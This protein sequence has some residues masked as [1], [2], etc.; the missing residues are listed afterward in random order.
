MSPYEYKMKR[1]PDRDALFI[2]V[3]G[4]PVQ[5]EPYGEDLHKKAPKTEWGYYVGVQWLMVLVL[6]E[7]DWKVISVSRKKELCHE[8]RYAKSNLPMT[9]NSIAD[10]TKLKADLESLKSESEGLEVIANYKETFNIPELNEA[11]PTNPPRQITEAFSPHPAV[12]GKYLADH[13]SLELLMEELN[14]VKEKIRRIDGKEG[15]AEAML[16]ALKKLE[17]EVQNTAVRKRCLKKGIRKE[18]SEVNSGNILQNSRSRK[19]SWNLVG[20]DKPLSEP[21]ERKMRKRKYG[22]RKSND[23]VEE[24]VIFTKGDRV[25]I[26]TKMFGAL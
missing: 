14:D 5:Y 8:E 7:E 16:K 9:I 22:G 12:Q 23:E 24:H 15:Q 21:A 3:F 26:R 11:T 10:F 17:D 1:E 4:C 6:R 18:A 2:H 20:I 13:A 19:I 25:K